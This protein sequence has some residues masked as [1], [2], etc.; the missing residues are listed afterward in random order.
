[1]NATYRLEMNQSERLQYECDDGL[2]MIGDS[3]IQ[4]QLNGSWTNHM[5]ICSS[6]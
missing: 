5:F 6:E 2:N 1:L 4:C 3:I